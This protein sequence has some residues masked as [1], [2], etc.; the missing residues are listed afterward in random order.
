MLIPSESPGG[1][2]SEGTLGLCEGLGCMQ[3]KSGN[4]CSLRRELVTRFYGHV[5]MATNFNVEDDV[6]VLTPNSKLFLGPGTSREQC[7]VK[8]IQHR[9]RSHPHQLQAPARVFISLSVI[10]SPIKEERC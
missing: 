5:T 6:E 8:R 10:A 7:E 9:P 2:P 3:D 1:H 4:S